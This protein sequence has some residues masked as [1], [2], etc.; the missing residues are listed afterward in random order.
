MV[1]FCFECGARNNGGKFCSECGTRFPEGVGGGGGDASAAGGG[2]ASFDNAAM[3]KTVSGGVAALPASNSTSANAASYNNFRQSASTVNSTMNTMDRASS[4][5]S[6][7]GYGRQSSMKQPPPPPPPPPPA[8]AVTAAPAAQPGSYMSRSYSQTGDYNANQSFNG[9]SGYNN[10]VQYAPT[11]I[12]EAVPTAATGGEAQECYEQCVTTI[13]NS[14]GGNNEPGV[15]AFKQNCK[16]YGLKQ[17][18]VKTFYDSLTAE[19][20]PEATVSFVPTLARLIPDDIRRREL[21]EYNAEQRSMQQRSSAMF[22]PNGTNRNTM[23]SYNRYDPTKP[24][25][26]LSCY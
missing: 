13:R 21:I 10:S 9:N 16:M 4:F 5:A 3:L 14:R 11:P 17:I 26:W 20:G 25:R 8:V 1:K 6:N 22:G 2:G 12:P 18:D 19:L 23:P 24:Y 7:N 15:K